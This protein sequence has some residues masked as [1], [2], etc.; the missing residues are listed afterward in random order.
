MFLHI[1][2]RFLQTGPYPA[3]GIEILEKDGSKRE[4]REA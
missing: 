2:L 3:F 4:D 1:H